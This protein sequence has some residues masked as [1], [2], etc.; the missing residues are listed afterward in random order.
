[1]LLDADPASVHDLFNGRIHY[2]IPVY[3]R[4]YVWTEDEQWIPLWRNIVE[5]VVANARAET[6][7]DRRPHFIGPI[8][9]QQFI[10]TV[11]AVPG[12]FI[13]DGQQRLTTIQIILA[14][15]SAVCTSNNLE[16][17]INI[18]DTY[19]KNDG[20]RNDDEKYKII[21]TARDKSSFDAVIDNSA[22]TSDGN[23]KEVYDFFYRNIEDYLNGEYSST[24]GIE[25]LSTPK[26]R[27][28]NLLHSVL[29]DLQV[30]QILIGADGDAE[31]VYEMV[32]G[33]GRTLNEFDHLR[34]N[35]FL[36]VRVSPEYKS[37]KIDLKDLH[38]D[39]WLHFEDD[40][41]MKK[42]DLKNGEILE[43][44]RF[45]QHFLMAKL[46]KDSVNPQDLFH[47]YN[48]EYRDILAVEREYDYEL[49]EI[50]K[51]S[52]VYRVMVDCQYKP[53]V[54]SN[55][56]SVKRIEI[57][58]QRM[59][60]YKD[61]K[62]TSLYPILLFS[63]NELEITDEELEDIFDILESYTIRRVLCTNQRNLD[64]SKFFAAFLRYVDDKKWNSV[65]LKNY[66]SSLDG[67]EEFPDDSAVLDALKRCGNANFDSLI[68]RYILYRIELLKEAG[69]SKLRETLTFS[70]KLTI[71]H[72]MPKEWKKHWYL[73]KSGDQ[74]NVEEQRNLA[75]QSIGNL[76]LLTSDT[77][78]DLG[79]KA[80]SVKCGSLISISDLKLT[81]EIV[82]KNMN[83][84]QERK[85]WDVKDIQEREEK[86]WKC[87]CR[88]LWS[89]ISSSMDLHTGELKSWHPS[90]SKGYIIAEDDKEIPVKKSEFQNSDIPLLKKGTKVKFEK[91]LTED[92]YIAINVI[93]TD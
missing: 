34:N 84:I 35:V 93:K 69:D 9:S 38:K 65:D 19:L 79:N 70:N 27:M 63:V 75:I 83:P 11:A 44:E 73:P 56:H 92:G 13:I 26:S 4:H 14:A 50:K 47:I 74:E 57:I 78:S 77:N 58:A 71:E 3:Q 72:V 91:I 60:F 46:K 16:T 23:I 55:S 40:F 17:T 36:K 76:T 12:Y 81:Q 28:A 41:W 37:Q 1:M 21:P 32:N 68:T 10:T 64:F 59:A 33:L 82:Y 51:Y 88:N 80:F 54:V 86:L 30:V 48:K 20:A 7:H 45:L 8:V 31:L 61:L 5:S 24:D 2:Q 89:D 15:I 49:L 39:H 43:A 25:N 62:N 29:H 85:T 53:D 18:A 42:L 67:N 66:L 6:D 52:E 22:Q 90:Y 87:I